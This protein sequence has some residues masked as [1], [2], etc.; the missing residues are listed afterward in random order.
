MADQLPP[1]VRQ[2][3]ARYIRSVEQLE[4]LL[5]MHD[6][7]HRAWSAADV[8]GVIRSSEASIA[9][10]LDA[11]AGEGFLAV[12]KGPPQTYRF[13]PQSTDLSSAVSE[14]ATAYKTWRIRVVEAIFAPPSDPVQSFADAFRLRKD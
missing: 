5:L 7:P 14:T 4:V 11:F 6:Q 8:Y 13:A 3:L 10:R 12:E 1:A 2:F 9:T